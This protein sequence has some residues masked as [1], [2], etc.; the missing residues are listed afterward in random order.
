MRNVLHRLM[1]LK[2]WITL[3]DTVLWETLVEGGA[4][5]AEVCH[6][7]W[8]LKVDSLARLPALSVLMCGDASCS[9][10]HAMLPHPQRLFLS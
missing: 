2:T 9:C 4:L 3:G 8:A 1:H 6:W 5:L 7:E 10:S